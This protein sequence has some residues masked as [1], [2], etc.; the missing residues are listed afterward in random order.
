MKLEIGPGDCPLIGW[1]TL[2]SVAWPG[3]TPTHIAKWGSEPLPIPSNTYDLVFSSHTIEHIPWMDVEAAVGEVCRILKPGGI[4]EC[5]TIDFEVIIK[6]YLEREIPDDWDCHQMVKC[7]T[8]WCAARL[9]AYPKH[10][11]D[12]MWHRSLFDRRHLKAKLLEGGLINPFDL[13]KTRGHD[14]GVVNLGVGAYKPL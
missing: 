4:F 7:P 5:W 2:D 10:G 9:Y 11:L 3:V 6:A 14:H 13:E 12:S 8:D 1:D